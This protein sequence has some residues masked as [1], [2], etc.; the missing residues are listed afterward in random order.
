MATGLAL[1]LNHTNIN[2]NLFQVSMKDNINNNNI[3]FGGN[4][5]IHIY[6]PKSSTTNNV[7]IAHSQFKNGISKL[8]AGIGIVIFINIVKY[9]T[10]P[11]NIIKLYNTTISNNTGLIGVGLYYEVELSKS[12]HNR[13]LSNLTVRN[14]TFEKN[15]ISMP[16]YDSYI[17][18][19]FGVTVH[20]IAK[21]FN[22]KVLERIGTSFTTR[23]E[24][25]TFKNCSLNTQEKRT[26]LDLV[27]TTL[28][29][30][31]M[32]YTLI[33]C[34]ITNNAFTGIGAYSSIIT[35]QGDII[36]KDNIGVN[37][38]GLMLCESSYLLLAKDTHIVF[39]N[40]H[41]SQTGGAV[42]IEDS[43]QYSKPFCFYQPDP[44]SN[45]ECKTISKF[46]SITM[47]NNTANFSGDH[48]YGGSLDYCKISECTNSTE[49]FESLFKIYPNKTDFHFSDVSSNPRKICFCDDNQTPNCT[50]TNKSILES[51]YP[52]EQFNISIVI[53][54]QLDGTVPGSV[55]YYNHLSKLNTIPIGRQCTNLSIPVVP[56]SVNYCNIKLFLTSNLISSSDNSISL[57]A[58]HVNMT[59]PLKECP[60]GFQYING[61]CECDEILKQNNVNCYIQN[62][63]IQRVP[64][65][66]I[67]S[68]DN[69]GTS[70]SG[71]IYIAVCPYNYCNDFTVYVTSNDTGLDQD[72]QCAHNRQGLLCS[73]C[74]K[75]SSLSM[76]TSDC[77][78][79]SKNIKTL[80]FLLLG[81]GLAGLMLVILLTVL[82]MTYIDGTFSGMLF[83][84]NIVT[85][86]DFIFL[87]S[88]EISSVFITILSW[89]SLKF[90]IRTCVEGMDSYAKAWSGFCFPVYLFIIM[91]VIIILCR[92]SQRVSVLLGGNV[93]KVLATLLHLSYT[94]LLQSV[95]LVLS[96]TRIKSSSISTNNK[97]VWLV[98]PSLEFFRSKHTPLA[99]VAVVFGL[100]ILAYTLVLLFVQP[101][102][103]YSHLRCF[104]W[105]AKLKPLI[106]AYTAPHVIKDNCRYWEGLL[107]LF[108]LI[109]VIVYA[110]NIYNNTDVDKATVVVICVLILTIAWSVGGTYKKPYLNI[111]NSSFIFNTFA[112]SLA[113]ILRG[114]LH[115]HHFKYCLYA[116]YIVAITTLAIVLACYVVLC[117]KNCYSKFKRS[118]Y[119]ALP[120]N[121][122]DDDITHMR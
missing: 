68:V 97:L 74:K 50:S 16:L 23:F 102:Q 119:K 2:V 88:K 5:F 24:N 80:P 44:Y 1:V 115:K 28:A 100:L 35:V 11:T 8:G 7:I 99:L 60:C 43:C 47:I 104:T 27:A 25:T 41:V 14:V 36:V 67:S 113:A 91:A 65:H 53:V 30:I 82:N 21:Y 49:I 10:P 58:V 3:A 85:I 42:Y 39:I 106:D 9:T 90:G 17:Q 110:S 121:A 114:K 15:M 73:K 120:L 34:N 117:A 111:L 62:N 81:Y 52:G 40:N 76:G 79:C 56:K 107:L 33:G 77:L 72:S 109:L 61:S 18:L 71:I 93:V 98:D 37:G 6:N 70:C 112:I 89:M 13:A 29:S 12:V 48:I 32:D 84:A 51:K 54:G 101:L 86:N 103:R 46:A 116:S 26:K 4:L 63:T 57:S 22:N 75:G 92:K 20:L 122:L 83:Y 55:S 31:N 95:V 105:V 69:S 45:W 118:H 38:G 108:R 19:G 64:P 87:D 66:W 94:N 78:R 96:F 59:I